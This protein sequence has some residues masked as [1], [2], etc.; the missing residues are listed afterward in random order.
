[1]RDVSGKNQKEGEERELTPQVGIAEAT[2]SQ[3][4]WAEMEVARRKRTEKV[5]WQ[6]I[7][8]MLV[9]FGCKARNVLVS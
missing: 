4:V 5:D 1:V 9:A 6:C 2:G 7:L 3:R 8:L